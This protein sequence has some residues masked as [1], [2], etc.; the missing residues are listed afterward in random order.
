M[1]L[2]ARRAY[3]HFINILVG[4]IFYAL[5][6]FYNPVKGAAANTLAA[7]PS[8]PF[9]IETASYYNSWRVILQ[10]PIKVDGVVYRKPVS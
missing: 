4:I 5:F 2:A 7:K 8:T 1:P 9:S 3:F 6:F 10:A